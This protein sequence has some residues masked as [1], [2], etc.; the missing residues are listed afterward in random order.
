MEIRAFRLRLKSIGLALY[1]PI[2][3]IYVIIPIISM[4]LYNS[5]IDKIL[6]YL[7]IH[8]AIDLYVPIMCA[9]WIL[10][11]LVGFTEEEQE[12]VKCNAYFQDIKECSLALLLFLLNL[13]IGFSFLYI[14][15]SQE[16]YLMIFLDEVKTIIQSIFF[17]AIV[18]SIIVFTKSTLFTLFFLILYCVIMTMIVEGQGIIINIFSQCQ[19]MTY[20]IIINKYLIFLL[21]ACLVL[22]IA[23]LV[24][25][26]RRKIK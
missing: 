3:V 25:I 10:C 14:F 4:L 23:I 16:F 8:N 20:D 19:F 12:A 9:W 13:L 17:A 11:I 2:I 22:G 1:P 18:Y 21:I 7:Y 24:K 6:A 26:N 5:N 15:F